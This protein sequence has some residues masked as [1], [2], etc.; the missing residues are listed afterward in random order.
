MITHAAGESSPGNLPEG[1]FAI[2]KMARD[3]LH[4]ALIADEL[5][6]AGV[7]LVRVHEPDRPYCGALMALGLR[8]ARK[9]VLKRHLRKLPLLE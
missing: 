5:Q 6:A 2:V 9:G 3:E 4:L 7:A 1:T 8:P